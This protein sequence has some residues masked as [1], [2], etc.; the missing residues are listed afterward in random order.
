MQPRLGP[1]PGYVP[2]VAKVIEAMV[3]HDKQCI[4]SL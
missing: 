3:A 1:V 4:E 2:E